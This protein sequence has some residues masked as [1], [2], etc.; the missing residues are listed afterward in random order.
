MIKDWKQNKRLFLNQINMHV[1]P[2]LSVVA[3]ER[4]TFE[5][6]LCDTQYAMTDQVVTQKPLDELITKLA[7][8]YFNEQPRFNNTHRCFWFS[9]VGVD[10]N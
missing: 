8:R 6:R 10:P 4:N 3:K 7:N 5:V 9:N 1:N 2:V